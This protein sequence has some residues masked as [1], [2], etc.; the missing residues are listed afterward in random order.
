MSTANAPIIINGTEL[1]LPNDRAVSITT[2]SGI[3]IKMEAQQPKPE[4]VKPV[5][6][7]ETP[8]SKRPDRAP[9][10]CRGKAEVEADRIRLAR[11]IARSGAQGITLLELKERLGIQNPRAAHTDLMALR[12]AG[13]IRTLRGKATFDLR[14]YATPRSEQ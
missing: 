7:Q 2:A 13:L 3:T 8:S 6:K 5:E 1:Q 11:A 9:Y 4:E 12:H 14:Y 10:N